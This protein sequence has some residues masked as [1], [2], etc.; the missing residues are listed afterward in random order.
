MTKLLLH[1][2][3]LNGQILLNTELLVICLLK[4]SSAMIVLFQIINV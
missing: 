4:I 1:E 2:V 3:I